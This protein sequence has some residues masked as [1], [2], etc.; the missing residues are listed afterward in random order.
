[1]T[2]ETVNTVD[3]MADGLWDAKGR[4]WPDKTIPAQKRL[5]DTL[6]DEIFLVAFILN[7]DVFDFKQKAMGDINSFI[8]LLREKYGVQ[9]GGH[10]GGVTL[11][12]FN[13]TLQITISVQD[14]HEFGPELQIAKDIINEIIEDES[15][16]ISPTLK[17]I[18]NT[19]F[20]VDKKGRVN[21]E[22]ILKLRSLDL[23]HPRWP[24]AKQA[25]DDSIRVSQTKSYIR[26]QY[27]E[28][29]ES[30]WKTLPI[31]IAKL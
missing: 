3:P 29:A 23:D 12:N 24:A 10:R 15:A 18:I 16:D 26:L 5:E 17:A 6:V 22:S 8:E 19:A 4:F 2:E 7:Q 21:R 20:D 11:K 9:K 27:R 13:E 31:D 30:H 14:F 1:M 25:I 28:N